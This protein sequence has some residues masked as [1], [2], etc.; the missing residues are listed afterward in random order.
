MTPSKLMNSLGRGFIPRPKD[1]SVISS[2][3]VS[4]VRALE[5]G[6][7]RFAG[8]IRHAIITE[9]FC[10]KTNETKKRR[11]TVAFPPI[12]PFKLYSGGN[13]A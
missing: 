5:I 7:S 9:N 8:D 11:T 12:P 2:F 1:N 6:N 13:D 10:K 4:F 3:L